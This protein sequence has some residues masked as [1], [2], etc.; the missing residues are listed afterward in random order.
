MKTIELPLIPIIV[1]RARDALA[2][3]VPEHEIAVLQVVHGG[4][5]SRVQTDSYAVQEFDANANA[6]FARLERTYAVPNAPNAVR[7][8]YRGPH[9]LQ[10]FGFVMGDAAA[11][12]AQSAGHDGRKRVKAKADK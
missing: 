12:P 4:Q 3:E 7:A 6:E 9:E 1:Q 5:V 11:E 2:V 8:V 10:A